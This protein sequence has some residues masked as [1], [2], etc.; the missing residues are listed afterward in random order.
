MERNKPTELKINNI[1]ND[2][3]LAD[4][5]K[6]IIENN[7]QA[8]KVSNRD[9]DAANGNGNGI[10]NPDTPEQTIPSSESRAVNNVKIS[11]ESHTKATHF[12]ARTK[13]KVLQIRGTRRKML[14]TLKN[15]T[16]L[17]SRSL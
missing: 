12:S 10:I 6:E 5:E 8:E 14:T 2:S 3:N 11:S 17:L 7:Q 13:E 15:I 4:S 16:T 1:N 9:I